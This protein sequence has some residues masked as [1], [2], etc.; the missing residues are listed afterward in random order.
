MFRIHV[1]FQL[2]K[3]GIGTSTMEKRFRERMKNDKEEEFLPVVI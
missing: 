3:E 1:Y 2:D